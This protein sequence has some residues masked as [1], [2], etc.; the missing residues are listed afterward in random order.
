M[1][2]IA[3]SK[4][5]KQ[6]NKRNKIY[7]ISVSVVIFTHYTCRLQAYKETI[8]VCSRDHANLQKLNLSS[9]Y[10]VHFSPVSLLEFLG[11]GACLVKQL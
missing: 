10:L 4:S 11:L 2:R 8:S 3:L 9:E 1:A 6:N 7:I 5:H